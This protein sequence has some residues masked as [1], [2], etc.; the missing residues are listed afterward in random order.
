MQSDLMGMKQDFKKPVGLIILCAVICFANIGVYIYEH[1]RYFYVGFP[2]ISLFFLISCLIKNEK[3]Q[4]FVFTVSSI[5]IIINHLLV[6]IDQAAYN[7]FRYGDFLV[8]ENTFTFVPNILLLVLYVFILAYYVRKLGAWRLFFLELVLVSFIGIYLFSEEGTDSLFYITHLILTFFVKVL[9]YSYIYKIRMKNNDALLY[10][11]ES[12]NQYPYNDSA[13]RY[14]ESQNKHDYHGQNLY[15]ADQFSSGHDNVYDKPQMW[16]NT[17][18]YEQHDTSYS[19][20]EPQKTNSYLQREAFDYSERLQKLNKLYAQ[21]LITE[22]EYEA[23]RRRILES[24]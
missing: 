5:L 7:Y 14:M 19:S 3:N 12:Y 8:R 6:T 20:G 9:A 13:L 21:E 24:I 10:H 16:N 17:I 22:E 15:G 4:R 23:L 18:E 1:W 2:I 11:N